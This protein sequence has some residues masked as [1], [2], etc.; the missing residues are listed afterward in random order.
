MHEKEREHSGYRVSI[1]ALSVSSARRLS[2]ADIRS[3]IRIAGLTRS[4]RWF[5]NRLRNLSNTLLRAEAGYGITD[6]MDLPAAW[7]CR[8]QLEKVEPSRNN[9]TFDVVQDWPTWNVH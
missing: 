9:C 6:S 8:D 7:A 4:D 3:C 1:S 2:A 5:G